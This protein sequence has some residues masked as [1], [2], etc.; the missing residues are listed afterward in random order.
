[1]K[2]VNDIW[3]DL[4]EKKLWLPALLIVIAIIA[5]PM[6]IAKADDP[7][8]A[9]IVPTAALPKDSAT[10]LDLTR[11]ST[12][13]FDRAPRVNKK[14][15]DPFAERTDR[16]SDAALK[17]LKKSLTAALDSA[18][19]SSST[20][21]DTTST[22]SGDSGTVP[23]APSDDTSSSSDDTQSTTPT[24]TETDDLLSILVTVGDAAPN[25][26]DDIRT[27]SPLPDS[28]NPFLVYTGKT[29]SGA[30]VFIVSAEVAPTGNGSCDPSP[31]DCRTLTMKEGD[32]ED[33]K[34]ADGTTVEITVVSVETG[35]VKTTGTAASAA[36]L[37]TK[38]RKVG[39]KVVK[40]ALDDPSILQ[41]LADHHVRIRH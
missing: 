6:R 32:T 36:R 3:S 27:L 28:T 10:Q 19:G 34:L 39:A 7:P 12:T 22:S 16:Q 1:M 31:E 4:L 23:V 13:G 2:I 9:E 18:L 8:P 24:K 11:A 37:E 35:K 20:G 5:V 30:A 38:A 15:L 41:S 17:A 25:E 29:S 33:F 14:E 40:D 21:S 26:M